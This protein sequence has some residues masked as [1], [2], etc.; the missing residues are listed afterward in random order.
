MSGRATLFALTVV[1]GAGLAVTCGDSKGPKLGGTGGEAAS[2]G[3][4]AGPSGSGGTTGGAGGASV[5]VGCLETPNTIVLPP[6]T[7]LP[8][9]SVPPGVRLP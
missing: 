8:C 5:L 7:T 9:D 1:L 3:G 2:A 6:T 4:G